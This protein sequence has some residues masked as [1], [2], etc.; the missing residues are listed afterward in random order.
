MSP[1]SYD[2]DFQ[3]SLH[4]NSYLQSLGKKIAFFNDYRYCMF[5]GIFSGD[6]VFYVSLFNNVFADERSHLK[7]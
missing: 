4:L 1:F 6:S 7:L 5:A 2:A 3:S